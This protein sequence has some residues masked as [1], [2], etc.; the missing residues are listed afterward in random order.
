[1]QPILDQFLQFVQ[2]GIAAIFKFVSL[3]WTWSVEQ[4]ARLSQAPWEHWALWKQIL[5]IVMVVMVAFFLFVA[6]RQLWYSGVRVLGAFASFVAALIYTLPSILMAGVVALGGLWVINN[7]K[8]SSLSTMT[9]FERS[10]SGSTNSTRPS[11]E[12]TGQGAGATSK[13]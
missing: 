6:A 7:F 1:M 11:R 10:D 12:T 9:V 5:L 13:Q 8:P 4:I 3:I 2:Q